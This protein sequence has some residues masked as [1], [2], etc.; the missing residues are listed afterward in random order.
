MAPDDLRIIDSSKLLGYCRVPLRGRI[1][2]KVELESY[3]V[4]GAHDARI[5]SDWGI[6]PQHWGWKPQPLSLRPQ[7]ALGEWHKTPHKV[8]SGRESWHSAEVS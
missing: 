2:A 1:S 5:E 7:P 4:T 6:L 3:F 8:S